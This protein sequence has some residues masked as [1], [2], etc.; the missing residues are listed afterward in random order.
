MGEGVTFDQLPRDPSEARQDSPKGGVFP[1]YTWDVKDSFP[2]SECS[3]RNWSG[4]PLTY[5]IKRNPARRRGKGKKR[6]RETFF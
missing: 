1:Y 2:G 4:S 5:I 3:Y 6:V